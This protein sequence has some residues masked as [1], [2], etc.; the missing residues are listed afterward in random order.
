MKYTLT[1]LAILFSTNA[2]A[3]SPLVSKCDP[4]RPIYQPKTNPDGTPIM[5]P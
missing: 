5:R 1:L 3:C 4:V 2:M